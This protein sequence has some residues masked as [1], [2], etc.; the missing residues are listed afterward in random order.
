MWHPKTKLKLI[1]ECDGF[2]YHKDKQTFENDRQRDRLFLY[3]NYKTMRFA[4]SEII[5]NPINCAIELTDFLRD[6]LF[7]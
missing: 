3:E 7:F 6:I 5:K 4:G 1:I 2:A